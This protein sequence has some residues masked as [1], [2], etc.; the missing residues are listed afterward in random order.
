MRRF[1]FGGLVLGLAVWAF[2]SRGES[3]ALANAEP[4]PRTDLSAMLPDDSASKPAAPVA[5]A[6]SADAGADAKLEAA[7]ASLLAGIAAGDE[8]AKSEASRLVG[9]SD[10]PASQRERITAALQG[11]SPASPAA[12]PAA[13]HG[14]AAQPASG[15]YPAALLASDDVSAVLA[16]LG[17]NNAFVHSAEGRALGRRALDLIGKQKDEVA[18]ETGTK[19]LELCMRGP[20]ERGQDEA[21]A[22]VDE[23]YKQHKVRADRVICDPTNLSRARSHQVA[24]GDSLAKLAQQWRKEGIAIDESSLAILNRISNPSAL[25]VGQRIRCPIDPIRAVL[26]KRSFLLAVYVGDRILRLYWVGHGAG[27]KTPVT[28]F[29]VVDKLKDPDWYSPDGQVFPAG[30]PENILGRYFI[31]FSNPD[32]SISGYG[33]HGTPR[34]ETVG[35]M[36][37]MGCIRMYDDGIEELYRILPRKAKVEVRDSK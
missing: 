10:L 26:E 34:P 16:G 21:I 24:R 7:L 33:A 31:K 1:V 22:F 2:L 18:V 37:S 15:A 36:S 27:D 14:N 3:S 19:F 4:G 25:R 6:A 30:S 28:E 20:V 5:E 23:A 8:N 32:P 11:A 12:K 13:Q 9:R 35:T 29:T 17:T